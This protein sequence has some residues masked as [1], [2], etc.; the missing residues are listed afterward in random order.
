LACHLEYPPC[1]ERANQH[2]KDWLHSNGTLN[3]P[4]D[5]AETVFS[6]GAQNDHGWTLLLN[7][8]RNSLSEAQ[9]NKILSALTSSRDKDKLQRLLEMGLEGNVIRS[10]D[11]S[12]L[13][14]MIARNPKGHHLA[15]NFVK[16]NWDALVEKFPLGS[17]G[18]RNII[19]GT[20]QQFSFPEEL[21]EVQQF[22][23]SIK[24]QTSQLRA[25]QL[26]LE[27][28]QKNIRWVQRNLGVLSNWLNEQMK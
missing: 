3:L 18:I 7:T 17:F 27:N 28:V 1:L 23:E 14:L 16:K 21:T 26:A 13:I 9:K 22:F 19:I 6:V 15:W 24:E 2:F 10:Q 12:Y 11:L 8:Y 20:T 4:T 5:V 25:T